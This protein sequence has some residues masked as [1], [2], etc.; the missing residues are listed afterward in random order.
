MG[1]RTR[2]ILACALFFLLLCGLA[3]AENNARIRIGV[4]L[5]LSGEGSIYG[6]DMKDALLFASQQ[7]GA[8]RYE[9][10]FEDDRCSP[11]DALSV[12]RKFALV[13]KVRFVLGFA[14]SGA[15]LAAAPVYE[16]HAILTIASATSAPGVREAGDFIFRVVPSDVLAVEL[17]YPYIAERASK[18]GVISE[19]TE[20]CEGFSSTFEKLA[21]NKRDVSIERYA[22]GTGDFRSIIARLKAGAPEALFLVPQM[23]T[24]LVEMVRQIRDLGWEIPLYTAY[25]GGSQT[26]LQRAGRQAEGLVYVDMP[27]RDSLQGAARDLYQRLLSQ[28]G[29]RRSHEIYSVLAINSFMALDA[30]VKSRQEPRAYLYSHTIEGL[31]GP[32]SFD[33][34]G[35]PEGLKHVLRVIRDGKPT[36]L[37]S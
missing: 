6:E 19:E 27:D 16:K 15:L 35:D 23:E 2:K 32:F 29:T 28:F 33:A 21:R 9:F 7:P 12:A 26:L 20:Y 10:I 24:T 31:F 34:Y 18:I 8:E 5:P 4:S 11:R 36:E 1:I 25:F 22:P 14:C 17:L 13:D 30:A 3:H 37:R